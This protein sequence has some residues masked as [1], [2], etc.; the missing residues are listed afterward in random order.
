LSY[1][2]YNK[3]GIRLQNKNNSFQKPDKVPF[4]INF[5]SWRRIPAPAS[6]EE[7]VKVAGS[8]VGRLKDEKGR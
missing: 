7:P 5:C 1:V 2:V 3:Y 6:P 8:A 4:Y